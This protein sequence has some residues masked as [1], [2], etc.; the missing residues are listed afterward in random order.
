M[1]TPAPMPS[2]L[3]ITVDSNAFGP[4]VVVTARLGHDGWSI[5]G[6][7]DDEPVESSAAPAAMSADHA[8]RAA[9]RIA[10]E[11]GMTDDPAARRAM[12][13]RNPE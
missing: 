7:V 11:L 1:T 10:A 5:V 3:S 9:L 13:E 6:R 2:H 4:H 8:A 12:F